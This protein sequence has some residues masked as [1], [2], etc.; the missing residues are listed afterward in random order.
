MHDFLQENF[1]R[2][3]QEASTTFKAHNLLLTAAVA[4]VG[5]L[6]DRGYNIP[7]LTK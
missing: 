5:D 3:I 1:A 6:V 7:V 4:P 2:L